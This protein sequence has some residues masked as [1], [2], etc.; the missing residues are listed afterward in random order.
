[1][2]LSE[3]TQVLLSPEQRRRVERAAA[4]ASAS[5]G[6]IIRAAIDAYLPP[7]RTQSKQ[8]A[9]EDL[10]ALEAPVGDWKDMEA[11]IELG[12]LESR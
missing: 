6:A 8:G 4:Q 12:F 11:E 3:R 5:V 2:S 9:L 1:M 7:S 10:F